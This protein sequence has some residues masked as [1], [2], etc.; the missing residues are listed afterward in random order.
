[1]AAG[2]PVLVSDWNGYKSTVRQNIDGFRV[3]TIS[4]DSGYGEDLAYD[5]MMNKIDYDHYIGMSVQRVAIDI[6]DCIEKLSILIK[7]K[8]KGK[9]FGEAG[10][11][12]VKDFYDWPIILEKYKNLANELD[13]I[14]LKESK[15]YKDFCLPS[16][17]SNRMDPFEVFSSYA[18]EKLQRNHRLIKTQKINEIPIEEILEF[19][20]INYAKDYLPDID[21]FKVI[22]TLFEDNEFLTINILLKET[23]IQESDIFKITIWFLKYGYITLDGENNE[24]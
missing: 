21:N 5:H 9:K 6:P 12:R 4:L 2:L 8:D 18:T 14:R 7:D 24:K 17:P 3:K 10:K 11:Q 20:S 13:S 16:L 1:M 23:S 15:N 22:N 19:N